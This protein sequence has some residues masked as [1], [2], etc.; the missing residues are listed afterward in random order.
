MPASGLCHSLCRINCAGA[1]LPACCDSRGLSAG[2][3]PESSIKREFDAKDAGNWLSGF[4]GLLDH[5]DSLII[6]APLVYYSL[7]LVE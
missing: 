2:D 7:R 4:G 3:L 6:V 1:E 5:I